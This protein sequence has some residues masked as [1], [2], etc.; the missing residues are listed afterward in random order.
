MKGGRETKI[1]MKIR[2]CNRDCFVPAKPKNK[3][4]VLAL[5]GPALTETPK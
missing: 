4:V 1:R 2:I 3:P 5:Y